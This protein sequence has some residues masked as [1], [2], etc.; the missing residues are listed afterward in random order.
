MKVL[1][2][3]RGRDRLIAIDWRVVGDAEE[4][5]E[6]MCE[7]I[8]GVALMTERFELAL[9]TPLFEP[10]PLISFDDSAVSRAIDDVLKVAGDVP[11][12][13]NAYVRQSCERYLQW[14]GGVDRSDALASANSELYDPLVAVIERGGSFGLHHGELIVGRSAIPLHNWRQRFA[15]R[16]PLPVPSG[17]Q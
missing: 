5:A 16:T 10:R 3:T 12:L 2:V 15:L 11:L 7:Y 6:L 14:C 13:R 9:T 4:Q 1:A 17:R 8:R